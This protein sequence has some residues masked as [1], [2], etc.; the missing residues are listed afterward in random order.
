MALYR[1]PETLWIV[2]KAESGIP[3][4]AQVYCD[5][6]SAERRERF[7][8]KNMRPENDE[9]GLFRVRV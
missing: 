1:Q 2:V 3:T 9:T 8:R 7:L 6:R 4:N 5:Q